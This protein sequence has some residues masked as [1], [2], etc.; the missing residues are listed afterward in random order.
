M[1]PGEVS[2]LAA[3]KKQ[4]GKTWAESLCGKYR[5]DSWDSLAELK[6]DKKLDM[7]LEERGFL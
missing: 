7:E 3:P 6:K 4:Q 2:I 5:D 1:R